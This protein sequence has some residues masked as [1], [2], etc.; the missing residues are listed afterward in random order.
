M[1]I[2]TDA[3]GITIRSLLS[4]LT[5]TAYNAQSFISYLVTGFLLLQVFPVH[6]PEATTEIVVWKRYKDFNKLHK[7]LSLLHKNLHRPG[8]FPDFPKPRIFGRS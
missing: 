3:H 6:S 5:R 4:L 1:K 8:I 7:T 2:C